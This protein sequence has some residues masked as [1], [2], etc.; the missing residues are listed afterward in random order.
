MKLN[1]QISDMFTSTAEMIEPC[2]T[3]KGILQML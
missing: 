2:N 1:K 3:I